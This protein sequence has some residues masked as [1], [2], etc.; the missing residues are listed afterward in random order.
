M[1]FAM[2]RMTLIFHHQRSYHIFKWGLLVMVFLMASH[3]ALAQEGN[4]TTPEASPTDT[5]PPFDVFPTTRMI[6]PQAVQFEL[7]VGL[8]AS[9]VTRIVLE[10]TLPD[11]EEI[12]VQFT[13]ERQ[14]VGNATPDINNRIVRP[15]DFAREF[16]VTRY[17]WD[18]PADTPVLFGDIA[19]RWRIATSGTLYDVNGSIRYEDTRFAWTEASNEDETIRIVASDASAVVP[20]NLVQRLENIYALLAERTDF[21][22][23]ISVL[24]YPPAVNIGCA[25]DDDGEP[26]VTTFEEN[27]PVEI[28]CNQDL[29]NR[30]LRDFLVVQIDRPLAFVNNVLRQLV[31]QF[32]ASVWANA[33]VPAWFAEGLTQIYAPRPPSGALVASRTN[34]R[35]GQA[36]TLDEM[37][38]RPA[39]DALGAWEAQSYGM[40]LYIAQ[41]YGLEALFDLARNIDNDFG[42]AYTDITEADVGELIPAWEVWLYTSEAERAYGYSIYAPET[43]TPTLTPSPTETDIP[44]TITPT[45]T[46]TI[47]VT[48]TPRPTRTPIPPTATVTPLPAEG[49]IVRATPQPTPVPESNL[50][51][52]LGLQTSQLAIIG[53]VGVL[54]IVILIV[55]Q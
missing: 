32:Y 3:I 9:D 4:T 29:A 33:D 13:D 45:P 20:A 55:G 24:V 1:R 6:F 18:V 52:D 11:G 41:M 10:I 48:N 35:S 31:T 54:M 38:I 37:A 28:T 12:L 40:V 26:V 50:A 21:R 8:P 5:A 2:Q 42:Q 46:A 34:L 43:A 39:D 53:V 36:L 15:Y 51:T 22:P 16:V 17:Q 27:L 30:A 49:F 23:T 47:F 19:Y 7:A 14:I 44:P 25:L